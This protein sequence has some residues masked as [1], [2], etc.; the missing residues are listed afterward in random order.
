MLVALYRNSRYFGVSN[1]R[2]TIEVA[3]QTSR[4]TA[5]IVTSAREER[6]RSRRAAVRSTKRQ[7]VI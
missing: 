4:A 6:S 3:L 7:T 1:Y 2:A 5:L